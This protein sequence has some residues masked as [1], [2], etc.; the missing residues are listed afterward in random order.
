MAPFD[1]DKIQR[2]IEETLALEPGRIEREFGDPCVEDGWHN[3]ACLDMMEY[4]GEP[5]IWDQ[6]S[7]ARQRR[8]GLNKLDVLTKCA[9]SPHNANG[10]GAL[11]GLATDSRIYESG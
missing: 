5:C 7:A 11:E 1:I 8:K 9:Q 2:E 6:I 10:Y 3:Q 4:A